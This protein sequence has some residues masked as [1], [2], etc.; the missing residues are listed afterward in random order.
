MYSQVHDSEFSP[1]PPSHARPRPWS[2]DPTDPLPS[3][4]SLESQSSRPP[5]ANDSHWSFAINKQQRHEATDPSVEALDL[6]DY[7]RIL[8]VHPFPSDHLHDDYP[9]PF[10]ARSFS[11]SSHASM[12]PP[13]LVS[14]RGTP[15]FHS[16]SSRRH[17]NQRPFPP[18][19]P[20]SSHSR[21]S[22]Y[23]PSGGI[24]HSPTLL[25]PPLEA[26]TS[27]EGIFN[28]EID[29]TQFPAW[30]RGW[31]A[32]D[33]GSPETKP[34]FEA[35][36]ASFFDPSYRA[37]GSPGNQY[38]LY[39]ATSSLSS[40]SYVPWSDADAPSYD[41]PLDPALK[42]ERIRMLEHEFGSDT[43]G[44]VKEEPV[45]SVDGE[46]R[47][48]TDGPKKRAAMRAV[49]IL[50]AL[51]SAVSVVYAALWIKTPRSPPP[52]SKPQTFALYALSIL[53]ALFSLY[54]FLFRPC[55]CRGRL[56][57]RNGDHRPGGLTVLPVQGLPGD[58]K[59]SG[60]RGK[61]EQGN[62]QVNLIMDPTMF[63]PHLDQDDGEHTNADEH[64][65]S[66]SQL[67]TS[68]RLKRR[69]VFEGLAIEE[70]WRIARKELQWTL[71]FD[72]ICFILWFLEFVWILIRER[73][74]P[75][76]FNGWCSAYN[77]ATAGACLLGFCF[78]V[79]VFFDIKDLHRS[80]VSPRTRT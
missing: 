75:G 10:S 46:G 28:A 20:V 22:V 18:S 32:K 50:L 69:S 62:V 80:R 36:R 14:S 35:S 45:G 40:R 4:R 52:Q 51:A 5:H 24:T 66:F 73:C 38:D 67:G 7:A 63:G 42:E 59:K 71:F 74:P 72:T 34:Q 76:G 25:R 55:C 3:F 58:K 78:G 33:S 47:L 68:R 77:V 16:T 19:I 21:S 37:T 26:A 39:A 6:A 30:S 31:Y 17:I 61:Q 27:R 54:R 2:P 65:S 12:H 8:D 15:T 29:I 49:E 57:R 53:T 9:H 1:L 13:S 44:P 79:S 60:K 11:V 70:Q 43:T 41:F 23:S 56:K 48:I 64:T